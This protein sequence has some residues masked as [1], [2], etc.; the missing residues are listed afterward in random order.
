[1]ANIGRLILSEPDFAVKTYI[2]VP[3]DYL[4]VISIK[5]LELGA[6]EVITPKDKL[7]EYKKE[8]EEII[9]YYNL[10]ENAKKL[11]EELTFQLDE[12]VVVDIK[13]TPKPNEF[14]DLI[15]KLTEKFSRI[16]NEIKRLNELI[17][18]LKDEVD[19]LELY[20]SLIA[21]IVNKYPEADTSFL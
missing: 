4:E 16:A 7:E 17:I 18:R 19:E 12:E 9:N 20:K 3:N 13:Y 2:V 14:K 21:D 15:K 6:L 11:Y 5:I 8:I 10:L 1:M